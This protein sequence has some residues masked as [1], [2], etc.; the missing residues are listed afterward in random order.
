MRTL[1]V[2]ALALAVST[3]AVRAAEGPPLAP[4]DFLLGAWEATGGGAP[5]SGAGTTSFERRLGNKVIV[6]TNH[7]DYPA[8]KD[9][10]ASSHDDLM[11]IY[12]TSDGQ[13]RASYY[14][15]EG[16]VIDYTAETSD[17]SAVFTSGNVPGAGRFR[18]TYKQTY[19]G[20]VSGQFEIAPAGD[21]QAFKS[22]LSW[23][24]KHPP[25]SSK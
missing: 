22:Y 14:D 21:P 24:M 11:V 9:R 3:A 16:H 20:I 19:A 13:I 8:T 1:P 5:G 7:A 18:L 10:P 15:S 6:R 12:A 4:L 25:A 17:G 23:T 2:L